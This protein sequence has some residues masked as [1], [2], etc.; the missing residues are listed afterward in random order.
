MENILNGHEALIN[1]MVISSIYHKF[2]KTSLSSCTD[3]NS[4]WIYT[5]SQFILRVWAN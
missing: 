1:L 2:I 3:G 5:F 4:I